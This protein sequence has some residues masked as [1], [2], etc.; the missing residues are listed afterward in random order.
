MECAVCVCCVGVLL[1]AIVPLQIQVHNNTQ[2][3]PH[4][5][6]SQVLTAM[7]AKST[8]MKKV[9]NVCVGSVLCGVCCA[10]CVCCVTGRNGENMSPVSCR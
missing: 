6:Q 8:A 10:V 7:A 2:Q 1:C 3:P 4:T 9:C 5:T